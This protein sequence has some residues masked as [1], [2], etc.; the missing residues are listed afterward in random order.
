M[1]KTSLLAAAA[2]SGLLALSAGTAQ[3]AVIP[4]AIDIDFRTLFD[5]G[6]NGVHTDTSGN[7][8]VTAGPTDQHLLFWAADD[9]LGV[10]GG[11]ND[12]IDLREILTVDFGTVRT[13][14]GAW[15]SDIFLSGDGGVNNEQAFIEIYDAGNALLFS[16]WFDGEETLPDNNGGLFADFG[17]PIAGAS[18]VVFSSIDDVNDEYSVVGFTAVPEPASLALLGFGLAGLAAVRRRRPTA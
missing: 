1:P 10:L 9:G 4:G 2:V 11:E 3:A 5:A 17:G 6:T 18:R 13:L 14:T 15:L 8:T 7:V 16:N 12:E